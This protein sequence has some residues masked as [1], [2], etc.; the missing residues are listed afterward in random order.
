MREA[1]VPFIFEVTVVEVMRLHG[2]FACDGFCFVLIPAG[3][4]QRGQNLDVVLIVFRIRVLHDEVTQVFVRSVPFPDTRRC[5]PIFFVSGADRFVPVHRAFDHRPALLFG[6]TVKLR[7]DFTRGIE[8]DLFEV[9][10]G[11]VVQRILVVEPV[12]I[13][14]GVRVD[15][16]GDELLS[17]GEDF[18]RMALAEV[19]FPY[20]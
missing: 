3:D 5:R 1:F 14:V 9:E 6:V 16:V 8:A 11:C 10:I 18:N 19:V 7:R 20:S 4:L 2:P 15:T 17:V 13:A 12:I